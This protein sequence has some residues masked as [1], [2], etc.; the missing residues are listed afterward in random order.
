MT[1]RDWI[2]KLDGF[3][4]L[5]GRDILTHAGKLTA[6]LAKGKAEL[7]YDAYVL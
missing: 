6:E 1:M 3:L 2:A 4:K 5:F 7:E